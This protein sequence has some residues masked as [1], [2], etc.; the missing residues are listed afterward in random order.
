MP[1][2]LIQIEVCTTNSLCVG[3]VTRW[4][5][6]S[7]NA[8]KTSLEEEKRGHGTSINFMKVFFYHFSNCT[9]L[10]RYIFWSKELFKKKCNEFKMFVEGSWITKQHAFV[11]S[12]KK[13]YL[14]IISKYLLINLC[15]LSINLISK[16]FWKSTIALQYLIIYSYLINNL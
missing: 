10:P 14:K 6:I 2:H 8:L 9:H 15:T 4:E 1:F 11:I 13:I 12:I 5:K 3:L 7:Q 16:L